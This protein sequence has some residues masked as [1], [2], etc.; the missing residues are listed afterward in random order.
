MLIHFI[1]CSAII[2]VQKFIFLLK[3]IFEFNM[4]GAAVPVIRDIYINKLF[5]SLL[6][7][8]QQ[9][10]W[11]WCNIICIIYRWNK[12]KAPN[13]TII[14]NHGPQSAEICLVDGSLEDR[15]IINIFATI[16]YT[17]CTTTQYP[18]TQMKIIST[19]TPVRFRIL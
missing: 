16:C 7:L 2:I 8:N 15:I 14:S 12:T 17:I 10:Y 11:F 4:S 6:W 19:K 1:P 5:M 13:Y 3:E 18:C 9:V